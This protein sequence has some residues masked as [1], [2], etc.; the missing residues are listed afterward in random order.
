MRI[1]R[2]YTVDPHGPHALTSGPN[3]GERGRVTGVRVESIGGKFRRWDPRDVERAQLE[4]WLI[5]TDDT[6]VVR[7]EIPVVD[8]ATGEKT[9]RAGSLEFKIR[10]GPGYYCLFTGDRLPGEPNDGLEATKRRQ[11]IVAENSK[12]QPSPDPNEPNGYVGSWTYDCDLV[13]VT[14]DGDTVPEPAPV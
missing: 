8:E 14:F 3:A 2:L 7:G 1:K 13:G 10:R 12:G 5:K 6:I 11:A 4:G 9:Y